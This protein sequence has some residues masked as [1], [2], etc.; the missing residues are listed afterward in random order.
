MGTVPRNGGMDA[1]AGRISRAETP[2]GAATAGAPPTPRGQPVFAKIGGRRA[3]LMPKVSV[4]LT[5]AMT[6]RVKSYV[7]VYVEAWKEPAPHV[8]VFSVNADE[9]EAELGR[10]AETVKSALA[11]AQERAKAIAEM[12]ERDSAIMKEIDVLGTAVYVGDLEEEVRKLWLG[13]S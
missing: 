12:M 3:M 8:Y 1:K 4:A 6:W 11:K 9:C 13:T 5:G 10:L 7:M 2:A